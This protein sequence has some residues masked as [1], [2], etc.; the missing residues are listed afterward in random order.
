MTQEAKLDRHI[1]C[2]ARGID[3]SRPDYERLSRYASV[4]EWLIPQFERNTRLEVTVLGCNLMADFNLLGAIFDDQTDTGE[5]P[6]WQKTYSPVLLEPKDGVVSLS[7]LHNGQLGHFA[8]DDLSKAPEWQQERICTTWNKLI[9]SMFN[10]K[11]AVMRGDHI[12]RIIGS[13]VIEG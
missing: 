2:E 7:A 9:E 6:D 8:E 10:H 5:V 4:G 12:S 1:L 3:P 11:Q 13:R